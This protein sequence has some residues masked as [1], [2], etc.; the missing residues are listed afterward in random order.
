M[1]FGLT[2]EG[3]V[4]KRLEDII[5]SLKARSAT[6][7][8]A[9]INTE[10]DAVLGQLIDV[11]SGEFVSLWELAEAIYNG[12]VPSSAEG[13]QLDDVCEIVG[14]SRQP[15]TSSRVYVTLTGD[16]GTVIP[17]GTVFSKSADNAQFASDT[18]AEIDITGL[19]GAITSQV[20]SAV[21][22]YNTTINGNT[23]T[24]VSATTDPAVIAAGIADAINNDPVSN[25]VV[26]ATH[27]VSDDTVTIRTLDI[28]TTA[29]FTVSANQQFNQGLVPTLTLSVEQAPISAPLTTIDTID[30]P[31]P[32]L[33]EVINEEVAVLGR[34]VETDTE[35]RIRRAE[36]LRLAGAAT[37]DAIRAAVGNVSGVSSVQVVENQTDVVDGDGRPPKSFEVIVEGGVD[38]DIAQVIWDNKPAG[39]A[40]YGTTGPIQA[41][42][43][44]GQ[45][46]DIFFSRPT[47]VDIEVEVDYSLYSEET[48]PIGIETAIAE[49]VLEYGNSLEIG[50]DVIPQR[51][52]G[53]IYASANGI[54]EIEV[55]ARIAPNPF[56]T[57]TI[58]IAG[59]ERSSFNLGSITVI[60]V[61]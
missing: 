22:N 21:G 35:L 3:F 27:N 28:R 24:Y 43:S 13:A 41:F 34:L 31:V 9:N 51:F 12:F 42:D 1:V 11:I 55:R 46:Q 44:E 59:S 39:I 52:Y 49:A 57:D 19:N 4:P 32:G 50:V 45:A 10:D 6:T 15:A 2:T 25:L 36:S 38:E 23:V 33:N 61:P 16:I 54:G 30:T 53:S 47:S 14:V 29:S 18:A 48:P 26:S 17:G 58:P 8:G 56:S 7:F 5:N 37:P 40:T 60:L 20:A